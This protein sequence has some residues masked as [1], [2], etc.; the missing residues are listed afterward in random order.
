MQNDVVI[1]GAKRTPIGSFQG[2][3][4]AT[5]ATTLGAEAI[6]G[7]LADAAIDS[8]HV[9]EVIMGCVLSAGLGQNPARQ[10]LIGAGLSVNVSGLTLN[11]VCGSGLKAL[12]VG[13]DTL[14]AGAQKVLVCG[15][16]ENMTN[17]PYLLDKARSGYRMGHSKIWDHVFLDGLED[18]YVKGTLM[19]D[20][21]ENVAEKYSFTKDM[22]DEFAA[23]S[24][25][26]A[27]T[28]VEK[29]YFTQEIVGVPVDDGKTQH[30]ILTDE[31]PFKAMPEK[32]GRLR[33]CFRKDGTI[34]AGTSS[35][36][37]DGAAAVVMT[38]QNLAQAF[39]AP[40]RARIVGYCTYAH[41]PAWYTTAPVF[42]MKNLLQNLGWNSSSVD[43]FEINE[44]FAV[45]TMAAMK[46]LNLSKEQVNIH[47]GACALGHPIGA[48]GSRIVITLLH[49][50]ETHG[51]KRG[52]AA[53]CIGGG[54]GVALAIERP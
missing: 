25:Q 37:A 43:L 33:P 42:A 45:V 10:A 15:G 3:F 18:A 49:A 46:D 20:Y 36:N 9:N 48:S 51:L 39:K 6:K 47:G 13:S 2:Q 35:S 11:K 16:M 7:A 40:I 52:I 21:A 41:D 5:A 17:A 50:L 22:Q 29:G 27:R 32:L 8:T 38:T 34:T 44:A 31:P 23:H 4:K 26:K 53:L 12:M 54:E 28:A 14:K 1:I 30:M 24:V 19:G